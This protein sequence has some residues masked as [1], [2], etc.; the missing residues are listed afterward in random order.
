MSGTALFRLSAKARAEVIEASE[1]L[2]TAMRERRELW[3]SRNAPTQPAD[4][5][6]GAEPED[7]E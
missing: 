3:Q 6:D 7:G 5:D 1:A 2:R 4:L